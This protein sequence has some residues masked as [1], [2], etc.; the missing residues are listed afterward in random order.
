MFELSV[1]SK[2]FLLGEYQVLEGGAAFLSVMEPRF[3]LHVRAGEGRVRGI[4]AGSPAAVLIEKRADFFKD[5]DLEFID[6]HEGRGGFGASTAQFALVKGFKVGFESFRVHA[7]VDYDLRQIHRTYLEVTAGATNPS[8]APRPSGADLISQFQ[9]G[10]VEVDF[11]GGKIHRH[12]WLFPEWQV[13]FFA[14]GRKVATHTHLQ[15]LKEMDL[16]PLKEIYQKAMSAFFDQRGADFVE[17]FD[18]YR[19][20]LRE[21]GWQAEDTEKKIQA[22]GGIPGVITAKGCGAM[23]SDVLAVLVEAAKWKDLIP[24]IE[25]LGVTYVGNLQNRTDGFAWKWAPVCSL[26]SRSLN[27]ESAAKAAA[28][29]A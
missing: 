16:Q 10:L 27:D 2:V 21:R 23:G 1:G 26:E 28:G 8:S 22:L 18:S 11:S 6:P 24:L 15:E 7:Q 5:W 4:G 14:T 29:G 19:V 12:A 13:L 17:A 3:Q 20:A 25:A 9:G